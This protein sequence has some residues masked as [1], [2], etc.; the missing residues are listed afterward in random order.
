MEGERGSYGCFINQFPCFGIHP[1]GTFALKYC[2]YI[3]KNSFSKI[4]YNGWSVQDA[5]ARLAP[6]YTNVKRHGA[7]HEDTGLAQR[8]YCCTV[9]NG[10]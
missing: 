3:F 10:S 4:G 2:T 7:S 8:H 5:G 9:H 1:M 6:R